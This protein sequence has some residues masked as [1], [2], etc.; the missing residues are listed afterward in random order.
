MNG[1]GFVKLRI[2]GQNLNF[3]EIT[4]ALS[5]KPS[6]TYKKGECYTP[7]YGDKQ[8]IVYKE[9]IWVFEVEKQENET[10]D[11]MVYNFLT[12]FENSIEYINKLSSNSDLT[13]WI[14]VYPDDEKSNIH[15]ENKTLKL[16]ADMGLVIEFDIM[17]LKDFYE[18]TYNE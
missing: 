13:L 8:P 15:L 5:Q 10:I 4:Q 17:F 18:G 14:S 1:K 2:A 11:N 9:D 12:N 6:C 3:E 16:I 7:K